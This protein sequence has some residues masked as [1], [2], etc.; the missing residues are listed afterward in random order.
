MRVVSCCLIDWYCRCVISSFGM[1]LCLI[2]LSFSCSLSLCFLFWYL[3]SSWSLS[4]S[5]LSL[6]LCL[7]CARCL[8][9]LFFYFDLDLDLEV[10]V[11]LC[12]FI[13]FYLSFLVR[14][15]YMSSMIS[16]AFRSSSRFGSGIAY[17][18]PIPVMTSLSLVYFT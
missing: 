7:E 10:L 5:A 9:C 18:V 17:V 4:V 12:F 15:H 2:V 8:R 16:I 1:I 6:E 13:V 11:C 14:F 3:L